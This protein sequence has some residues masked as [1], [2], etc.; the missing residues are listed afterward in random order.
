MKHPVI[1]LNGFGRIGKQ[2][3]VPCTTIDITP[4]NQLLIEID[5]QDLLKCLLHKKKLNIDV[6]KQIKK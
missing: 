3:F 1:M 5:R 6:V 4:I 2:H